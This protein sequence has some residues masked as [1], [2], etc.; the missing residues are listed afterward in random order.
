M[1]QKVHHDRRVL[2]F[3]DTHANVPVL[4]ALNAQ[5]NALTGGFDGCQAPRAVG[6]WWIQS[7]L[8]VHSP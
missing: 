3:M 1:S 2:V 7:P 5:A 4:T 8:V 6:G